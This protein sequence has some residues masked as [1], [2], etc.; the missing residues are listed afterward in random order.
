MKKTPKTAEKKVTKQKE[1][2]EIQ[3]TLSISELNKIVSETT[4]IVSDIKTIGLR[5]ELKK[6][7]KKASLWWFLFWLSFT[8]VLINLYLSLS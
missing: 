5:V 7:R 2:K 3:V 6:M 8:V 1:N 4:Q